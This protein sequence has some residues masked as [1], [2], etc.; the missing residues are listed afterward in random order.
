MWFLEFFLMSNWMIEWSKVLENFRNSQSKLR[1]GFLCMLC[2]FKL[3]IYIWKVGLS[4]PLCGSL[5]LICKM[6]HLVK[7][8]SNCTP[9]WWQERELVWPLWTMVH[10]Q[11]TYQNVHSSFIH[12]SLL[13]TE[14]YSFSTTAPPPRQVH[15]LK[16]YVFRDKALRSS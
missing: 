11:N 5:F 14:F 8:Q 9:K 1:R 3:M 13:G 10:V 16:S 15:I 4:A 7:M 2:I 12:S 6:K